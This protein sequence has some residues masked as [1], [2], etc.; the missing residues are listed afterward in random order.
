MPEPTVS[1]VIPVHNGGAA[2]ERCLEGVARLD[3]APDEVIVVADGESDGS[4]RHAQA[5]GYQVIRHEPARGPAFARN[6]GA[7]RATGDLLFFLDADV[8]PRADAVAEVLAAFEELPALTA[9][10]GSYDDAPGHPSWLSQYRNLL[11]HYTHQ[12]ALEE[13]STFW[14]ACAAIRR[15]AYLGV[16]GFDAER[17]ALPSI[18]DIELGYRLRR[19][20]HRIRFRKTLQVKHLK[21]WTAWSMIKTDVLQRGIP[22]TELLLREQRLDDDLNLDQRSRFSVAAAGLLAGSLVG[23]ARWPALLV[24]AGAGAAALLALNAP[25]YRYLLQKRGLSFTLYTLPWHWLYFLYGGAAFGAG[26]VRHLRRG[27]PAAA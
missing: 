19:G 12:T 16:G 2:F 4:W 8:I 15:E 11:H 10:V 13:G 23:A 1:I 7:R 5:R 27:A 18:E 26:L 20:G 14:G 9:V 17:Y 6:E 3:P 24:P 21:R 22:W 25:F